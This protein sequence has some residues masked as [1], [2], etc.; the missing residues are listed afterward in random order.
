MSRVL[1]WVTLGAVSLALA[2]AWERVEGP[3]TCVDDVR[4]LDGVAVVTV[5]ADCVPYRCYYSVD[6]YGGGPAAAFVAFCRYQ[7]G[8][9]PT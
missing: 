6:A 4:I 3:G 5:Y 1:R 7:S 2:C 9:P 8:L